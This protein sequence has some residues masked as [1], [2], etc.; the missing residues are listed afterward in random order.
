M[1]KLKIILLFSLL[2][3]FSRTNAAII[4]TDIADLTMASDGTI[5]IDFNNDGTL[6]FQ[7]TDHAN[8][9]DPIEVYIMFNDAPTMYNTPDHGFIMIGDF[10]NGGG[11]EIAGLAINT[12]INST[13]NFF[14]NGVDGFL[15][16]SWAFLDPFPT[17]VDTYIGATF[18]LDANTHYG[19]IRIHWDGAGTFIIKDYA[20]EDTPDA[21]ILA[22]AMVALGNVDVTGITVTGTTNATTVGEAGTLQM[23]AA[24]LPANATNQTVTWSVI[25]GTGVAAISASGL[26]SGTTQGT[27][28][29]I[30]TANDGS[31][32]TGQITITITQAINV[33]VT[34]LNIL[35]ANNQTE[36]TLINGTL[37]M[38]LTVAP[39][40]AT[41]QTVTWTVTNQ[42]GQ[43]T[44][45]ANGLL[46]AVANGTVLVKATA[47]DGSG[48]I[49][50][51]E[52]TINMA[53]IDSSGIDD[54][55][56]HVIRIY[57]NP[58]INEITINST[59][60]GTVT[61]LDLSGKVVYQS[62]TA[63]Q[64]IQLDH[65]DSGIYILVLASNSKLYTQKIIKK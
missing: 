32:I 30:A 8:N 34:N 56:D 42:T 46:T 48:E 28:T 26:L 10:N 25:N 54:N 37:Q 5:D 11:D 47:N 1:K 38:I 16:P 17:N 15:D 55:E 59:L 13:S 64:T 29:V 31:G 43:A 4:Y 53:E 27:I 14:N 18:K 62:A 19:W 61:I 9:E 49:A 24:V 50:E 39:G 6:E 12:S 51:I 22:G 3:C 21:T 7:F 63:N 52:I 45:D 40:N 35:T 60:N 57:P 33:L 65:L 20:Y 36:I 58:F 44:I 41:N 2:L 23:L